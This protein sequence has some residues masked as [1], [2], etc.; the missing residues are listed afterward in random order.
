[1]CSS[2]VLLSIFLR[3]L[4]QCQETHIY[5]IISN[6]TFFSQRNISYNLA[7]FFSENT[8]MTEQYNGNTLWLCCTHWSIIKGLSF[9]GHNWRLKQL[10]QCTNS[11]PLS[12]CTPSICRSNSST[13][14]NLF[15]FKVP[16]TM[17]NK[18]WQLEPIQSICLDTNIFM[19]V[20][21]HMA[22]S[23]P[24]KCRMVLA[25]HDEKFKNYHYSD[26][27]K[28]STKVCHVLW[29]LTI[30]WKGDKVKPPNFFTEEDHM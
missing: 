11:S 17:G 12:D 27:L 30:S 15:Q 7:S 16:F 23:H 18:V 28:F 25:T 14:R 3:L 1:M 13:Y 9:C 24:V 8:T 20:L 29:Y 19:R 2:F 22:V 6:W 26:H 21:H 5:Y 4:S 10:V